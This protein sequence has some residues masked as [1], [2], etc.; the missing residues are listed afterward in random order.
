MSPDVFV[1][2]LPGRHP[3]A[4]RGYLEPAT[5]LPLVPKV[6]ISE[7]AF[8]VFLFPRDDADL[9]DPDQYRR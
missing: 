6:I 8:Q 2:Y 9:H 3:G 1:T 4:V 5:D 7:F